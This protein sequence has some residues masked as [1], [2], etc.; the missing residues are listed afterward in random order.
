MWILGVH[1]QCTSAA[2]DLQ[3][4]AFNSVGCFTVIQELHFHFKRKQVDWEGVLGF[5]VS[6]F[7]VFI[8]E[9]LLFVHPP[10]TIKIEGDYCQEWVL[11]AQIW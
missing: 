10:E 2:Y 8:H 3:T 1:C 4:L 9:V 7:V 6:G 11:K 5:C